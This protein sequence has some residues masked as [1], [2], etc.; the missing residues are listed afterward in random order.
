MAQTASVHKAT[1]AALSKAWENQ[2]LATPAAERT[3]VAFIALRDDRDYQAAVTGAERA[4]KNKG[5]RQ[6]CT[7]SKHASCAHVQ[8]MHPCIMCMCGVHLSV[9]VCRAQ[10]L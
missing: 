8:N 4:I 6:V 3:S 10:A 1:A 9:F 7:C 5:I 2:C